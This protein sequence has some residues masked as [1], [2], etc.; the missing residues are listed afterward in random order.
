MISLAHRTVFVHVPKCGGQSI[1]QAFLDDIGLTWK[2]RKLLMLARKPKKWG[3]ENPHL[4][5]LKAREYLRFDYISQ[6]MWSKFFTFAIVRNPFARVASA[7]QYLDPKAPTLEAFTQSLA[8]HRR[9]GFMDP[10][11]DYVS[12][13]DG[14]MLVSHWYRL[15]DV[16]DHWPEIAERAGLSQGALPHRNASAEKKRAVIWTEAAVQAVREIYAKDFERF[17]YSSAEPPVSKQA[18]ASATTPAADFSPDDQPE[19]AFAGDGQRESSLV[20]P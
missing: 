13:K 9:K 3:G 7:Y 2:M 19:T 10:A 11:W 8:Q 4:A 1:E 18:A 17:G 15:E 16:N 5:H 6:E 14:E 20:T 12:G